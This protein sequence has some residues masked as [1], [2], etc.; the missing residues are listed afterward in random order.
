V[1]IAQTY[2]P[3]LSCSLLDL[4]SGRQPSR[5]WCAWACQCSLFLPVTVRGIRG[6]TKRSNWWK[7][8]RYSHTLSRTN[9]INANTR[10]WCH[11]IKLHETVFETFSHSM[12][13]T[14]KYCRSPSWTTTWTSSNDCPIWSWCCHTDNIMIMI[15]ETSKW[16]W[17][18]KYRVVIYGGTTTCMR[19]DGRTWYFGI[20]ILFYRINTLCQ[21]EVT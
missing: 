20:R 8:N 13:M 18:A 6:F 14:V 21:I 15:S 11:G 7:Y 12:I 4:R 9:E 2:W 5:D 19:Y 10:D 17:P 16:S 1:V 3:T